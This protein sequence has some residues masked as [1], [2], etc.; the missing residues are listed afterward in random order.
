MASANDL[1]VLFLGLETLSLA[2]YVLAASNRRQPRAAPEAGIKYFV[3]GGFSSAFF[4]YGIALVYGATGSTNLSTIVDAFSDHGARRAP[5]HARARRHR[6][7]ARRAR[8]QGRRRARSTSGRP[9]CTRARRRR[10]PRSWRRSARS[11]AFAALLRVFVVGAAVLPRR[12]APG[13]L[14]AGACC[15]SWSVRC[16]P[17]CRPT[18][19]G[20][21]P[22]RRSATPGSSS[23]A[24]RPPATGPARPTPGAGVPG[25]ARLPARLRGA[26]RSA[27][28]PSS[29]SSPVSGDRATDLDAF[30]GLGQQHPALALA[31]TVFLVAQAGVPFTSGFIAKFGVDPAPPSRSTATRSPIIAMVASVIAAFLYL[32]IMV[33]T[34]L[35]DGE[36][37]AAARAAGADAL[38]GADP[39]S[40]RRGDR[41]RRGVHDGRR[42]SSPAGCSTP[43][44][45]ANPVRPLALAPH[46]RRIAAPAP[47]RRPALRSAAGAADAADRVR[48]VSDPPTGSRCRHARAARFAPPVVPM[49]P[50]CWRRATRQARA[51]RRMKLVATGLLFLAAAA[52]FVVARPYEDGP[53]WVGYVRATA[54]AAMVGALADW[55][56]VTALFRHPLGL[57]IPHTAIIPKRKD[58][59]G[60]SLGEFVQGNFLTREVHRRAPRRR[61]RRPAPR[62]AGSPSRPTPSA[63]AGVVG[64]ALG[65]RRR[66][67]RRPRRRRTPSAAWS[68]V[69]CAQ[70]EVAPLLGRALDVGDR[71]RPPPAAARRGAAGASAGFLDENRDDV[72]RAAPAGVAVV[73]ARADRRPHL[74]Q[75]LQRRAALPRRRRV[76]TRD[77]EVR[78]SIDERVLDLADRLR[79]D[80]VLIAKGEEL[81]H[82]LLDAPRGAG[83]AAVAVG[84]AEEARCSTAADDPDERAAAPPRRRAAPGSARGWPTDAELQAQGRR[85]GGAHA[86]A[87]S[88]SNYKGEVGRP[89]R[90]DG[91]ALGRRRHV[92]AHRAAGRPRPPVHPHQRHHRRRPRRPG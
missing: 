17:S 31:L 61:P 72:P 19:S 4:L 24:S 83:V 42:A 56:A 69:A 58:Q 18:S 13:D 30:R 14:G 9:T 46:S 22:T 63:A 70:I 78:R 65:G 34:W 15:R 28:S 35:Q 38:S 92:P 20:C 32:R 84:R 88:S 48:P 40:P 27:R 86:S 51:L 2:F 43:P 16:S 26:R 64:D 10:S 3:L 85:L 90:L 82:E 21:S 8:L 79:S 57:P 55:F 91:R 74:R 62:A 77:H 39:V 52:V 5:R 68:S 50:L 6:P 73:G 87:T 75:D 44:S 53:A 49:A 12:L 1:I 23:S 7:A 41:R 11:A 45:A 37:A 59:I 47:V 36:A 33:A 80:P 71:G 54:E 76:P 25:D 89:H 29:P 67:A 81:K 60:R 66:G